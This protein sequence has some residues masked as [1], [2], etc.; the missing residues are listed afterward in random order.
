MKKQ[1]LVLVLITALGLLTVVLARSVTA[2]VPSATTGDFTFP[3]DGIITSRTAAASLINTSNQAVIGPS[4]CIDDGDPF[5]PWNSPYAPGPYAYRYLIRIPADYTD[6]VVRVELFDPDSINA[7]DNDALVVR[8]VAAQNAPG[9]LP[10]TT[11]KSCG[12]NGGSDN[13]RDACVL[14]T[15]ELDL[16]DTFPDVYNL[17]SINPLWFMRIDEN[18]GAGSP[19]GNGSC[20]TPGSYNPG[21][22]TQTLFQLFYFHEGSDGSPVRVNLASYTGQV[23]DGMRDSGDHETDLRWVSPGGAAAPGQILVPVDPGSATTFELDLAQDLPGILVDPTTGDRHVYLDVTTVSGASENGF[24]IWAGP[25]DYVGSV[26]DNVNERNVYVLNN[27]GAHD[28]RGVTISALGPLPQ[29]SN[30]DE[31]VGRPLVYVDPA[32]ADSSV[33]V[34]LYDFDADAEP[35]LT[36]YFDTIAE[37]D[38]SMTFGVAGQDDPDG[39]PA[40]VRCLPG[41]CASQWVD[42]PYEI[43]VP[44]ILDDCD[45]QNPTAEDCTPFY[46]GLLMVRSD[47]GSG[48]SFTWQIPVPDTIPP[49][50]TTMGCAAFPIAVHEGTRSVSPPGVGANPYPAPDEFMYPPS[51]P[52]YTSFTHHVPDVPLAQAEEGFV[53]KVQNGPGSGNFGWLVWN[54]GIVNSASTLAKSLT[55]PGDSTDYTDHGDGGQPLPGFDHVV[56]GYVE[57]VDP[58]DISMHVGDWVAASAGSVNSSSVQAALNAHIDLGRT[59][60]LLVWDS[61]QGSGS[62]SQFRIAGFAVFRLHGYSLNQGTGGSWLLLEFISWD[63]SCG[64]PAAEPGQEIYFP[65]V[66]KE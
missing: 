41:Q 44:G 19:P 37:S 45:W 11:N 30:Y 9:N 52:A 12:T 13:Q 42:P 6:D 3:A 40:G 59:L 53:Y 57:P 43:K 62:S 47:A 25:D 66:F 5:S 7:A 63:T 26:P 18:R 8:T 48:N 50:D 56:R 39:V 28:S 31:Q 33:L 2:G 46:G 49:T 55:W 20:G 51:P 17:D 29:N 27:P 38:W 36:F 23:G 1:L 10:P 15:D 24:E 61:A 32:L 58:T 35:P 21:F 14:R 4:G 34:S 22:N 64:Q 16:I 54:T 65:I 60:R